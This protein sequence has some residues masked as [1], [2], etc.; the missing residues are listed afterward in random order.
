MRDMA[1]HPVSPSTRMTALAVAEHRG[2][3]D[4]QDDVG[5]G[6]EDVDDPGD[7]RVGHAAEEAGDGA[8][9][10]AD[11]QRVWWPVP[12]RSDTRAPYTTRL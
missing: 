7:A 1:S 4:R 10:H 8:E 3:G 2:D 11:E 5:D 12:M 6:E 9:G